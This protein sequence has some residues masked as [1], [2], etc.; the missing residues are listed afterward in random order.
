ML[1]LEL[2][3]DLHTDMVRVLSTNIKGDKIS[4]VVEAYLH[5][6]IGAGIDQRIAEEREKYHIHLELELGGDVFHVSDDTG[7]KGL[8]EGILLHFFQTLTDQ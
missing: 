1:F 3:Y 5:S 8:R 2:E 7:N 4:E 6:Q